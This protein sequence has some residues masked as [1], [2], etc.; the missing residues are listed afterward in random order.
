MDSPVG[1]AL[2]LTDAADSLVIPRDALPTDD[3]RHVGEGDFAVAAWIHPKQLE[4]AA[5]VSLA[6]VWPYPG[7]VSGS[8][9]T[10]GALCVANCRDR[11]MRPMVRC[12]LG[13]A[14]FAPEPGSMSRRLCGAAET[15]RCSMS[16]AI[17]WPEGP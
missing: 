13:R 5:I 2:S 1:K 15:K 9:R 17:W 11:R 10:R 7:L 16:T 8:G 14:R 3:A 12:R 6:G 4:R